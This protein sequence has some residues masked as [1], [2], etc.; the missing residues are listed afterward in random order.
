MEIMVWMHIKVGTGYKYYRVVRKYAFS[1]GDCL[2]IFEQYLEKEYLRDGERLE[3]VEY[4]VKGLKKG[5]Y[6]E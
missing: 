2:D 5:D 1:V 4:E 6:N 3:E